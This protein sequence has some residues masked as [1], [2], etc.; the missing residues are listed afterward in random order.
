MLFKKIPSIKWS[1]LKDDD[2][3][4]DVREP[5][6]FE[7]FHAKGAKN[8][9]LGQIRKFNTNK[10]VYVTCQSGMRSKLAVK[11]LRA[12]GIDAINIKGG[13]MKYYTK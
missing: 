12:N 4:I 13:M 2:F 9:P 11:I 5:Y 7:A 1:E 3:I 8:I 6:E 10:R